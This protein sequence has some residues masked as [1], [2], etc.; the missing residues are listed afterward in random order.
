MFSDEVKPISVF[1]ENERGIYK[2]YKC[3]FKTP[4][5]E[6]TWALQQKKV[7]SKCKSEKLLI[8]FNGNTSGRDPFD[9]HGFR[10]RRPECSDCTKK[11]LKGKKEAKKKAKKMGIQYKP[12]I[13]TIC[14]ICKKPSSKGNSIV[15]DHCH[16]KNTFRGYCC[17]SC[18]RSIGVLGDN[19]H[20]IINVANYLLK[21]DKQKIIQDNN[22]VLHITQVDKLKSFD[23]VLKDTVCNFISIFFDILYS[24]NKIL[25]K[26]EIIECWNK[27]IN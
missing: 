21:T 11:T 8:N 17:N 14:E 20:G 5:E 6:Y 27:Y 3:K 2:K 4:E 9:K 18:N 24:K 22:G 26:Q 1:T 10:L 15:F 23:E 16:E 19:I 25:S 12:S 7:C 13:E